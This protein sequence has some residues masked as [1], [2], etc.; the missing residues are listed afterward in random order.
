MLKLTI[1]SV[2]IT[3][4]LVGCGGSSKN[5]T[6][7]N[8]APGSVKITAVVATDSS[9]NVSFTA[10]ATNAVSYDF[11]FGNGIIQ[12]IPSGITTYKY[13]SSGTYTVNVIAKSASGL[14]SSA[15]IQVTVAVKL[16]LV[17]SDE[18]NTPGSP[19]PT[20][21]TYDL[22]AGGWGNNELEYYT[23]RTDNAVVSN[24]T[25]KI[26]AKKESYSGSSYT[27][28]R[29]KTQ[30]LYAFKYGR[31]DVSAK[32][33]ASIGTWPAIWM[34]GN[35]ISTVGWPACGEIDIMEQNGNNKNIVYGTL[36]YPQQVNQYGDGATTSVANASTVFHKYSAIWSPTTIQLLVDDVVYY[37]LPNNS[38][39]PFNQNFFIILNVAMGGTLGG[40]VDPNFTTDQM[41]IDY[42][43]VY[44]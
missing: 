5:P 26:I 24:G 12:T 13:T 7:P 16:N 21:W 36:H 15:N 30:G 14:T 28:A 19:D 31:I 4:M 20:K 18:F 17:W 37:T 11:D 3:S 10:S 8:Q 35:N 34:L 41:E 23:S 29:L 6:P 43:R 1:F 2:L 25:L 40:T 32:L 22:G 33:P 39:F 9:G 38:N 27:S 42:V 44:Q